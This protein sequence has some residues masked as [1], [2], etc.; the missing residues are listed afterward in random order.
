MSVV[1]D[2]CTGS[3]V[4]RVR[5]TGNVY[6]QSAIQMSYQNIFRLTRGRPGM[7]ISHK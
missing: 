2:H 5:S 4:L 3:N 7:R 6:P 1:H